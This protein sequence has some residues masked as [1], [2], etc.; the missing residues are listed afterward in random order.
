[1][2]KQICIAVVAG[3]SGG[4]IT[5]GITYAL[6]RA[7]SIQQA[8]VLLFSTSCTFDK[9]ILNEYQNQIDV[10][11]LM[12]GRPPAG[13]LSYPRFVLQLIGAF[14]QSFFNLVRYRP[15]ELIVMGG[16]VSIPV[17]IA[18][19][20]LWIPRSLYELNAFPGKATRFLAPFSTRIR[21]CFKAAEEFFPPKKIELVSYP[22]RFE[23]QDICTMTAKEHLGLAPDKCTFLVLGGSQGSSFINEIFY[24]CI[25]THKDFH[26]HINIIHQTGNAPAF[27]FKSEYQKVGI[28]ARVFTYQHDLAKYYQAADLIIC[29]AGAGT[30]FEGI[31][32]EKA[33]IFI[34]LEIPGNNHQV[35]NAHAICMQYPQQCMYI[36]QPLLKEDL[37]TLANAIKIQLIRIKQKN[38]KATATIDGIRAL[39]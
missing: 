5:P 35:Y 29:R 25:L 7:Q 12:L 27:D 37:Q 16:Y 1:M 3:C 31:F 19:W 30:I 33:C 13:I 2:K 9:S 21:L 10:I 8:R 34:P 6:N 26:Q 36:R 32:F 39:L 15:H 20:F 28:D 11:P 22:I 14:F 18:A 4:H 17:C 38:F 24:Q 23:K